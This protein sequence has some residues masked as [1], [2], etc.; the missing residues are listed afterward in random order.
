M[1]STDGIR[2]AGTGLALTL[3]LC[4]GTPHVAQADETVYS[5]GYVANEVFIAYTAVN[6]QTQAACPGGGLTMAADAVGYKQGQNA[7]WQAVAPPGLIIVAA[8]IPQGALQSQF[9][10]AGSSG[11][12]GGDFYWSGGASN[13]TPGEAGASFTGLASSD[14]GFQLVCGKPTCNSPNFSNITV[15]GII[16]TVRDTSGPSLNSPSGL[17]QANGWIRGNWTLA[18][19]GDSPSGMCSLSAS[20][21][22][23]TLPGASSTQDIAAWHQ[24]AAAAVNDPVYTAG[25]P[26]G[27]D[28]LQI[29]GSDAANV[30]TALTKTVYIDNQQPT[31]T[32]SGPTAAPSTGGTQYVTATAT[33]GPSGVAGISCA[34][35]GTPAQ[36]YPA[37]TAQVPVSGIGQHRVQCNSENNAVDSSGVRATSAPQTFSMVIGVPTVTAITFSKLVDKLRCRRVAERVRVPAR[38]K[39]IKRGHKRIRVLRRAHTKTIHVTKCHARTVRR[40]RTV[41]VTVRR[42]GKRVRLRRRETVRVILLPHVVNQTQRRVGHGKRT[43]VNGW[44]GTYTGVALRGQPVQVLTAPDNGTGAFTP[45]VTTTTAADGGWSATLPAGPS[46]LVEAAYSG[47]SDVLPSLSTTVRETVPAEVKLISIS[48]R[49]VAWG[50]TIR[51]VGQLKGGYLPHGGAL[52]RLRIGEGPAVTTYGVREHVG[53]SGRFVTTYTFGAGEPATYRSFWFQIASLPMGDY[54]YGPANSRRVSVLVGGHPPPP[55][56][57]RRR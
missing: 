46:R 11:D 52:V 39:M 51:L 55:H 21:A 29:G 31:L 34:V 43:T 50:G 47:G 1:R 10:N 25:Y 54:P 16:L 30:P 6:I 32:L 57:R 42:H 27:A 13:I 14:F 18:F 23:Q 20:L 5:C 9:V 35:D 40:R 37:P 45:L 48:P 56:H 33:A 12:F 36:W 24:C 17:W 8:T 2:A 41:W 26:Q 38:W 53:G 3:A 4:L 28:T 49:R 7:T 15:K 19:S 22:G 44:L